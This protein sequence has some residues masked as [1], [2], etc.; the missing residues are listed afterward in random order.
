MILTNVID[1]RSFQGKYETILLP[2]W[3]P[4]AA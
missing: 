3:V 1:L 4:G 2:S